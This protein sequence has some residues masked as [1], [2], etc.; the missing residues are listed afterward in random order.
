MPVALITAKHCED[1]HRPSL[2][3]LLPHSL[4]FPRRPP[5][6]L[7][8]RCAQSPG[9]V[10]M[11]HSSKGLHMNLL[12][13]PPLHHPTSPTSKNSLETCMTSR[14]GDQARAGVMMK[15]GL[16]FPEAFEFILELLLNLCWYVRQT[17]RCPWRPAGL[18][19]AASPAGRP[20]V[21]VHFY[22]CLVIM[23]VRLGLFQYVSLI[24]IIKIS[25]ISS[26]SVITDAISVS[27]DLRL[28][29]DWLSRG[30]C[31]IRTITDWIIEEKSKYAK[32]PDPRDARQLKVLN[33]PFFAHTCMWHIV[34]P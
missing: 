29:H 30:F 12:V 3:L 27:W 16:F 7:S 33:C 34:C 24:R 6:S 20:R 23:C 1:T 8:S 11:C 31:L 22:L 9:E 17:Q 19:A 14:A 2:L 26:T 28:T 5:P 13:R 15:W 10:T 4:L 25:S 18:L 21:T 32:R